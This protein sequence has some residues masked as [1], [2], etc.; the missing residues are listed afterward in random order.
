MH[1]LTGQGAIIEGV[2]QRILAYLYRRM[3]R[4]K[5]SPDARKNFYYHFEDYASLAMWKVDPLP[6]CPTS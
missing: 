3:L 1:N 6:S 5:A 4:E 2:R